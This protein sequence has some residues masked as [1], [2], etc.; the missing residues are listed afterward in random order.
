MCLVLAMSIDQARV[1]FDFIL[2]FL[3]SSEIL[4]KEIAS[5]T[6]SEIRLKNGIVIATHAN[7]FRSTR[8]RKLVC[9]IF[10]E[11]AF[12]RD[13]KTATPDTETY[14][15]ILP[16]LLPTV[17]GEK[18]GMLIDFIWPAAIPN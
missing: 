4:A 11:L 7:S 5:M 8:G 6:T 3:T 17:R 16:S 14:T 10:D 9:C 13:D 2:G 18:P 1:V 15:A 12:W